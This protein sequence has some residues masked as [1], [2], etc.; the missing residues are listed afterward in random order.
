MVN[1]SRI[2]FTNNTLAEPAGTELSL[3]DAC[4]S[5]KARGYQVAA[6]STQLGEIAERLRAAG[7]VIV[8]DLEALPWEPEVIHG[9]HEWETTIAALR[10][11]QVPVISF[12]RGPYLWQEAPCRAPN[13]ALYAAVDEE[14]RRRLVERDGI[15]PERVELVLNGV[16]MEKFPARAALP[17]KPLRALIFSN[18]ATDDNYVPTVRSACEAEGIALTI[19]GKGVNNPCSNPGEILGNFDVVFSKGKA[20]LEA[21]AVGCA[22][23]VGDTAGLGPLVNCANFEQ[24]RR[25]SFGNPCMTEPY[26]VNA[27]RARLAAFNAEEAAAVS[28]LVRSTCGLE[29][30]VDRL[31]QL[32]DIALQ[33]KPQADMTAWTRFGAEFLMHKAASAKLG[34]RVQAA[35]YEAWGLPDPEMLSPEEADHILTHFAQ[36]ESKRAQL[37]SR[38]D[39][40]RTE[41]DALKA[42]SKLK[43]K[44]KGLSRIFQRLSGND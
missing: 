39:R 31:E 4:L 12:C 40:L 29:N 15:V 21:L 35:W 19:V 37:Q 33:R 13:V 41:L 26:T 22:L 25:L 36:N 44:R 28:S 18:Y 7:A 10:W 3:H 1:R 24:L 38:C 6:F 30:T 11:P 14:C 5:L 34:R 16:S 8:S 32:Y 20:A 43:T 27:V 9:Q 23:V 17:V 42:N 2:L